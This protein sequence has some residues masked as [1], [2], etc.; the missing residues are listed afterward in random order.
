M[1]PS[2]RE[3]LEISK[4]LQRE[5]SKEEMLAQPLLMSGEPFAAERMFEMTSNARKPHSEA[6]RGSTSFCRAPE[7]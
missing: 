3:L 6:R 2:K 1:V 4:E 5:K 7:G